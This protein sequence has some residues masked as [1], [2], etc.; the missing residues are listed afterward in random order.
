[1]PTA[2]LILD[3]RLLLAEGP[4]WLEGSGELLFVDIEGFAVHWLDPAT[5]NVR[6]VDVGTHVGAALPDRDGGL[7]LALGGGLAR[8]RAGGH[9]PEPIL[10]LTDDPTLR[11][12]DAACDRRGR[13]LAGS[14][15]LDEETPTGTLYRI[16]PDMQVATLLTDVTVSNGIDWSLDDRTMYFIDSATGRVDRL[17]YDVETGA[18]TGRRPLY[19]VGPDD[20]LPDGMCVDA[21]G[22]LWVALWGGSRVLGLTPD[23][24]PHTEIDVAASQVTS[25]AFGGDGYRT[26]FITSAR[27]GLA[28]HVLADEPHAGGIF[29]V[30]VGVAGLP[31]TPFAGSEPDAPG[32]RGRSSTCSQSARCAS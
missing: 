17:D 1:M 29:A 26:L 9:R 5:G 2:E 6:S 30:D 12:N 20:G 21:E 18:A 32:R 24:K 7:V 22:G 10:T 28:E 11:M 8:L 3:A 31:P 15:P 14:M 27:T 13:L 25:M 16:D 4:V 19:T 23:G